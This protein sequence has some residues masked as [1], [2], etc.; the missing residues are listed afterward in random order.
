MLDLLIKHAVLSEMVGK[1]AA[2]V[3]MVHSAVQRAADTRPAKPKPEPTPTPTPKPAATNSQHTGNSC[4]EP[5]S[6]ALKPF[7]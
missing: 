4:Q 7:Q 1:D 5:K 3:I 6:G 2:T